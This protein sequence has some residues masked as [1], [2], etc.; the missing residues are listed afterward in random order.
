MSFFELEPKL[1]EQTAPAPSLKDKIASFT[2]TRPRPSLNL[3]EVD[4]VAAPHGFSS[5]E[6]VKPRMRRR[7]GAVDNEPTRHL[8]MRCR[9]SVYERFLR[10]AD[11]EQLHYHDALERLLEIAEEG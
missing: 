7:L 10:F 3:A 1:E 6:P 4:A 9:A 5:R 2:T 8:A 11:R